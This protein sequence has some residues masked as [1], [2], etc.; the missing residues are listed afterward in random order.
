[1]LFSK[2]YTIERRLQI[3]IAFIL[4]SF[5]LVFAGADRIVSL[6]LVNLGVFGAIIAGAFYTFGITTPFSMVVILELMKLEGSYILAIPACLSATAVDCY[7]FYLVRQ[8]LEANSKK[9]VHYLRSKFSR[10]SPLFPFAGFFVFGL[11]LP[12]ELGL[13]LMEMT[14]IKLSKLAAVIFL[15]KLLTLLIFWQALGV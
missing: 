8:S 2:K 13:A 7:F 10:F 1:M 9:L 15:A 6:H 4:L 12:D 11:P 14:D 5:L 3:A